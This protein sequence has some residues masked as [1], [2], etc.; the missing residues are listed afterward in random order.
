MGDLSGKSILLVEDN[1]VVAAS[2][3][4][5]LQSLGCIVVGPAADVKTALE[6]ARSHPVDGALLDVKLNDADAYPVAVVLRDRG[7]PFVFVTGYPR[8]TEAEFKSTPWVSKP[9]TLEQL[10]EVLEISL[11]ISAASSAPASR[12]AS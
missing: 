6:L 8:P 3:R 1:F 7:V 4:E 5:H 9:F 10:T 11:A 2:I 12:A